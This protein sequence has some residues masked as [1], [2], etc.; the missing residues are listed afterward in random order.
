M[1]GT[2]EAVSRVLRKYKID[3]AM[4]LFS[5]LKDK[6]V[7]PKDKVESWEKGGVVYEIP[8]KNCNNKYIGETGRLFK[9]RLEEH[10]KEVE[11]EDRERKFTRSKKVVWCYIRQKLYFSQRE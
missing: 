6:L 3:T 2:S 7:H 9:T 10:R 1:K 4:R 8:S 5:T 11:Q